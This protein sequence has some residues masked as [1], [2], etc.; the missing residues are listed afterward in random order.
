MSLAAL[1]FLFKNPVIQ[2]IIEIGGKHTYKELSNNYYVYSLLED[3][4]IEKPKDEN[5]RL[6]VHT[7]V[8]FAAKGKHPELIKLLLLKDSKQAFLDEIRNGIVEVGLVV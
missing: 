7:T 5:E 6:Y 2:K 3:V 4:G 8:L 1:T